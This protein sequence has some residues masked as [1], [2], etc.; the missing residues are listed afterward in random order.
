MSINSEEGVIKFSPEFYSFSGTTPPVNIYG[1]PSKPTIGVFYSSTTT[2]LQF[3]DYITPGRI[4]FR[5]GPTATAT[6][7]TF[8]IKSQEVP[9]YRWEIQNTNQIF[10]TEKNTWATNSSGI[11]Q[12][13]YQSL[14]RIGGDYF[15]ASGIVNDQNMRGYIF[16]VS[17]DTVLV[18]GTNYKPQG[19]VLSNKNIV[20]AP[21]HFYFGTVVGGTAIEKFKTKYSID[22]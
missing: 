17:N 2:N 9:F 4:D 5:S 19:P 10:G 20:G 14:D 15:K 1:T 6:P 16:N 18:A 22:E 21:F 3:K 11:V 12:K 7:Y 13:N 8:G